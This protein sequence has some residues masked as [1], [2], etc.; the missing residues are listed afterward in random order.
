[1]QRHGETNPVRL[2][3]DLSHLVSSYYRRRRLSRRGKPQVKGRS[4]LG[5]GSDK[6]NV[7]ICSGLTVWDW[8]LFSLVNTSEKNECTSHLKPA[9][10]LGSSG[11]LFRSPSS[12]IDL[13][14]LTAVPTYPNPASQEPQI[15][16]AIKAP[17][18]SRVPTAIQK[19]IFF[20]Q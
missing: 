10:G 13:Q 7:P 9:G 5:L 17:H 20:L 12:S 4:L 15:S 2:Q 11:S 1:M 14:F 3:N 6:T 8:C 16:K 18:Q 19:L